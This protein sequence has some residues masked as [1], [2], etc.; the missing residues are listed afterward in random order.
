MPSQPIQPLSG[1]AWSEQNAPKP[2]TPEQRKFLNARQQNRLG[3]YRAK[4]ALKRAGK[5]A[6][7]RTND[8]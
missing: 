2:L 5:A 6:R 1:V 4:Q 8:K 3:G 7:Q